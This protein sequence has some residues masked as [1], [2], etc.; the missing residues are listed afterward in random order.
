MGKEDV[1]YRGAKEILAP[2]HTALIVVDMQKDFCYESGKFAQA[3]RD[4]SSVK[5]I[6]PNCKQLLDGARSAGVFVVHLQQITLPQQKSDSAGWLAFKTRDGKSAEYALLGSDG[7]QTIKELMPEGSEV[8]I[9]KFRPS[10]FHGTF[11][12]QILRANGVESVLICGTT[13]EGC[14]MATVLDAS[15]YDYYT[16]VAEDASASSVERMQETAMAFMKTRY[17]VFKAGEIVRL[18]KRE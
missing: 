10:G 8:T 1:C 9:Q 4:I 14:V 16:C 11:L 12:D 7:A 3:G 5:G 6:I 15:F 17:K 18:W 2:E 13:T